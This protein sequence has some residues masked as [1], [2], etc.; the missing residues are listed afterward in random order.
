M[1]TRRRAVG[2][3]L[4]LVLVVCA[5]ACGTPSAS[6]K[7]EPNR[8]WQVGARIG[9]AGQPFRIA[10]G[11]RF[12]WVL[13]RNIGEPPGCSVRS[14]CAVWQIDP[15]SNR[16]VGKPIRLPADTWDLTAGAGSVWVT[17]F[18]GRLIR[19]NERTRRVRARI[20]ARPIYFGSAVTFGDG[21]VWTGNDDERYKRGSTVSKID[22]ATNQVVGKPLVV[23]N[24]QS[25]AFG[26]G[27][28]WA[29]DHRGWLVK[30]DPA[31]LAVER[32]RRLAFGPHGVVTTGG[33]VYVSDAH[34]YR[35]L[36]FDPKTVKLRRVAKL[37]GLP[38]HPAVGGG[39]LWSGSAAIWNDHTARDD[40]VA[41]I[42]PKTL[43]I[44][45]T[46]HVGGNAR[47]VGF[48]FGSAWAALP[49]RRQ[50]VRITPA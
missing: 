28:L 26:H 39:S 9:V 22:P 50:V 23:G 30:I 20:S 42:D 2:V 29:A 31:T 40:R 3:A 46:F 7:G 36:E 16:I 5:T 45:E 33:A 38:I 48:G 18:D 25:I 35:L 41:R 13:T 37:S 11:E 32:R 27:A 49:G 10:A 19:I 12:L 15:A 6:S 21:F 43:A 14:P 44:A 34:G 1:K 24:S 4:A 17:Q 47:A 8:G